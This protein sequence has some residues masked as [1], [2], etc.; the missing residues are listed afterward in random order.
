MHG[1]MRSGSTLVESI[2]SSHSEV[3]GMGEDSVFNGN[4]PQ[5][6]NDIVS[7]LASA[8]TG[9]G[10]AAEHTKAVNAVVKRHS[11]AVVSGMRDKVPEGRQAEAVIN[12]IVDKMLFNFRNVGFIHLLFPK[13]KIIHTV[14]NFWDVL[15][16]CD[17]QR[18]RR[19]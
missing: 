9:P 10:A 3:F 19:S 13:A 12:Y 7:I 17:D 11:K 2:L 14:R 4:L 16:S 15:F 8:P 1:V 6:R 5:I 18:P